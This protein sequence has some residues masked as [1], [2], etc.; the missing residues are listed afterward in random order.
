MGAPNSGQLL[1]LFDS[2]NYYDS[3]GNQIDLSDYISSFPPVMNVHLGLWSDNKYF[4]D[5]N[6]N[7]DSSLDYS[8][9]FNNFNYVGSS[10]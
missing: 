6:G 1:G 2:T 10:S 5:S 4:K 9:S 7:Y 3:D 8:S